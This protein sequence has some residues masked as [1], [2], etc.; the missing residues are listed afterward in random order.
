MRGLS[1]RSYLNH[2]SS[3]GEEN[4]ETGS[5]SDESFHCCGR[6]EDLVNDAEPCE[7]LNKPMMGG[8]RKPCR[9]I[10]VSESPEFSCYQSAIQRRKLQ[11]AAAEEK[12]PAAT[13]TTTLIS[14]TSR[15]S[16]LAPARIR[17]SMLSA[18][19]QA[20]AVDDEEQEQQPLLVIKTGI[21][22]MVPRRPCCIVSHAKGQQQPTSSGTLRTSKP[23]RAT[24]NAI[25]R[26]PASRTSPASTSSSISRSSNKSIIPRGR[27][28]VSMI[29]SRPARTRFS[30]LAKSWYNP[31]HNP[32]LP[33]QPACPTPTVPFQSFSPHHYETL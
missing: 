27:Q 13:S 17:A 10:V 11:A 33:H 14:P 18:D 16:I 1:L 4:Q 2:A 28:P 26:V 3:R 20:T 7:D 6:P 31:P 30:L 5:D 24:L 19:S 8:R 29:S 25:L 15:S 12:E 23:R 32:G 22:P 9:E 21:S